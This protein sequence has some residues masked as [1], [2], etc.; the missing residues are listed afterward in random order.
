VTGEVGAEVE[1]VPILPARGASIVPRWAS[2]LEV[3]VREEVRGV[4]KP[5][6]HARARADV[7]PS[8]REEHADQHTDQAEHDGPWSGARRVGLF[9][10]LGHSN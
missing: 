9:G 7:G 10:G 1:A 2:G 3:T 5:G 6:V 8:H 4:S